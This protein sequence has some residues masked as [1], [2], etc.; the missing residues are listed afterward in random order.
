MRKSY[1]LCAAAPQHVSIEIDQ[2]R[3]DLFRKFGLVSALIF[4][5]PVPIG[6]YDEPP[7][8]SLFSGIMLPDEEFRTVSVNN[9][10]SIFIKISPESFF[11]ELR[12]TA[13]EN[14]AANLFEIK[15]GFYIADLLNPEERDAVLQY[16]IGKK[17]ILPIA[18]KKISLKLLEIEYLDQKSWQ[19]NIDW[20]VLWELKLK[21]SSLR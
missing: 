17:N 11:I 20:S 12:K 4:D 1:L 3:N 10:K 21:K 6:F 15:N 14:T 7:E 13:G 5:A 18:W 19:D 9:N 2:L 16:I 8:K